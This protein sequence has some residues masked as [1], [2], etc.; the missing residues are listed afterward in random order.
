MLLGEIDLFT[1][2][3]RACGNALGLTRGSSRSLRSGREVQVAV[4]R[5]LSN[6]EPSPDGEAPFQGQRAAGVLASP[7]RDPVRPNRAHRTIQRGLVS[8]SSFACFESWHRAPL[9]AEEELGAYEGGG[10]RRTPLPDAR[11]NGCDCFPQ[12][13]EV[14]PRIWEALTA[15]SSLLREGWERRHVLETRRGSPLRRRPYPGRH[16]ACSASEVAS[17]PAIHTR[18]GQSVRR[19]PGWRASFVP[20]RQR[21]LVARYHSTP[22]EGAGS[23]VSG[24]RRS[25]P[26]CT[27]EEMPKPPQ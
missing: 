9:L 20:P 27:H 7:S 12:E 6:R 3:G 25:D 24:S 16:R 15:L 1:G 2:V 17:S 8:I 11:R 23:A 10:C 21:C 4:V 5:E 18:G 26:C 13:P 14:N 19:K 22:R